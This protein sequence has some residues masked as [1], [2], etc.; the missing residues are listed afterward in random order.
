MLCAIFFWG[1]P[2]LIFKY[3]VEG[4]LV[5]ISAIDVNMSNAIICTYKEIAGI[6]HAKRIYI[7]TKS[8]SK[9]Y[10]KNA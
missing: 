8:S 2:I 9:F 5:V 3:A 4:L 7:G 6:V 1:A 10:R